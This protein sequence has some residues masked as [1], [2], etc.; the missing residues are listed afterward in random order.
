MILESY[1][2]QYAIA[3][4]EKV[5]MVIDETLYIY[6][7]K[8]DEY[9]FL[10]Q[11]PF[12]EKSRDINLFSM[13]VD[14]I[15]IYTLC[16]EKTGSIHI[17]IFSLKELKW[18]S[19]CLNT[20]FFSEGQVYVVYDTDIIYLISKFS[21]DIIIIGKKSLRYN[22]I[23]GWG[24]EL[25]NILKQRHFKYEKIVGKKILENDTRIVF[26][27][28]IDNSNS[29]VVC[30]NKSN[31]YD[32]EVKWTV[33]EGI[34]VVLSVDDN[35]FWLQNIIGNESKLVKWNYI[36]NRIEDVYNMPFGA[37]AKIYEYNGKFVCFDNELFYKDGYYRIYLSNDLNEGF[38]EVWGEP[39]E[40][41][42]MDSFS[43]SGE[44]IFVSNNKLVISSIDN[45]D[46]I[47]IRLPNPLERYIQKLA[48]IF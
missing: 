45:A 17:Y 42:F 7:I 13:I 10:S 44:A 15:D 16:R 40:S 34:N 32:Y 35:T 47:I 5:Y 41:F 3:Q 19:I 23:C 26:G 36:D 30:V 43:M 4:R 14:D 21:D 37:R 22:S 27:L 1:S 38:C 39:I 12:Q 6:D 2:V 46:N 33:P 25:R 9:T 31:A 11:I 48:N 20:N 29:V 8:S 28:Q 24:S 18:K